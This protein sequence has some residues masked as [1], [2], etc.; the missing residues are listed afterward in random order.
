[1]PFV[2]LKLFGAAPSA[3]TIM[4]IQ[5]GLTDLMAEILKKKRS[6]TVVEIDIAADS[7]VSCGAK[8]LDPSNWTGRLM[9]FITAGTNSQ[10]EKA[11]F[12]KAAHALLVER[13]SAPATPLYIMVQ[14]FPGTDWGYGGLS[15]A[16]RAQVPLPA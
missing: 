1:M 10:E 7:W 16:A 15:Q 3:L 5:H 6:L 13:L 9:A 14:E 2:Q 8:P 11:A 12:Q 4:A